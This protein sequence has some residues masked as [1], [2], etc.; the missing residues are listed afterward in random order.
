MPAAVADA[1]QLPLARKVAQQINSR[2]TTGALRV[3]SGS[4]DFKALHELLVEFAVFERDPGGMDVPAAQLAADAAAGWFGAAFFEKPLPAGGA[5]PPE[6]VGFVCWLFMYST[7]KGRTVYM[8]DLFVRPEFRNQG[9]GA[10]RALMSLCAGLASEGG[11]QR[12]TWNVD[13]WNTNGQQFYTA[14]GAE[15]MDGR[16]KLGPPACAAMFRGLPA[17]AKL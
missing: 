5:A 11:C 9:T 12:L 13:P 10:G 16:M 14:H 6:R 15:E 1:V 17:P 3:A 7:F 2:L 8:I 4:A